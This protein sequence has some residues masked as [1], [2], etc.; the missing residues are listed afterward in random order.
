MTRLLTKA[1]LTTGLSALIGS[2]ALMAQ[3]HNL[4]ADIPFA[5]HA[6]GTVMPAGTYQL[7]ERNTSG[8]FQVYNYQAKVSQFLNAPIPKSSTPR[9]SKLVFAKTGNDYVLTEI[10]IAGATYSHGVSPSAIRRNTTR[11]LGLASMISV[12]LHTK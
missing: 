3:T 7:N 8:I 4:S 12:P 6:E 2:S 11:G 9:E 10:S 5:F 1:L